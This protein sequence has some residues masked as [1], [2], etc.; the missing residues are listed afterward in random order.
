MPQMFPIPMLILSVVI[1]LAL[2]VSLIRLSWNASVLGQVSQLDPK[3]NLV[4][5]HHHT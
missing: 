3:K 4:R 5:G 2:V 1:L